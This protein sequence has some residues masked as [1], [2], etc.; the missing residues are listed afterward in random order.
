MYACYVAIVNSYGMKKVSL[1]KIS[2]REVTQKLR[3]GELSFVGDRFPEPHTHCYKVSSR[4][5]I[6]MVT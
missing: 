3:N 5:F 1:K 2:Q 6:I 4:Y